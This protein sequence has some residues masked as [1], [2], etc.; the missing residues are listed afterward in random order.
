MGLQLAFQT[1]EAAWT[2]GNSLRGLNQNLLH[3]PLRGSSVPDHLA[4]LMLH[5]LAFSLRID[6]EGM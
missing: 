6:R 5:C 1:P 3:M 4:L 2:R